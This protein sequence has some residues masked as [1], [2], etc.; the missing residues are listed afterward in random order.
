M[1]LEIIKTGMDGDGIAYDHHKPVFVKNALPGEIVDVKI[2]H[3][4]NGHKTGTVNNYLKISE[5]RSFDICRYSKYCGGCSI[6]HAKYDLQLK[7]KTDLLK[8]SLRKYA[9]IIEDID[10]VPS[11]EVNH[12]RN[13]FKLPLCMNNKVELVTALYEEQTNHFVYFD[14]CLNHE[15]ILEKCRIEFLDIAGRYHLKA[16]DRYDKKGLRYLYMRHL[17][18]GI[19]VCI[20]TGEETL[21]KKFVYDIAHIDKVISIYQSINTSRSSMNIFGRKMIHL[22][23]SKTLRFEVNDIKANLSIR[24]FYQMNTLQAKDL[25]GHVIDLMDDNQDTVVEAYCGVGIMSLMASKKA[26]EVTGIEIIEDAIINAEKNAKLNNINNVRFVCGDSGETIKRL[27]KKKNIDTLIVDPPRGGL[28]EMM[29]ETIIRSKIRNIIYVSCND[30]TLAKNIE[31]L[32]K[33]YHME[34]IK[35]FDMFPNTT[36]VETVCV[37]SKLSEAKH[38]ISVQ[39]DMDELDLYAA[40]SKATY[41]EIQEWVQEKYGF[42]V[43]HL[44]IAKTKRKCGIIERQNYNLPKSENSR[45]PE[46]PKE[47][48]EAIIDAFLHF[49]M[50]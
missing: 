41:E 36:H 47:K 14:E 25:Y 13:S 23:G 48:E 19:Q 12:Y 5:D 44:N 30:V 11:P 38:H 45:S 37:L 15:E 31:V 6:D 39:V 1:K 17:S 35:A 20:V 16:Y 8:E 21:D 32:S 4:S 43:T 33:Y 27:F 10:I 22:S 42:H 7:I 28:D 40:E 26:K 50:M 34:S 18:N 49:K 46:T 24:S 2:I 3:E 9:G 29:L